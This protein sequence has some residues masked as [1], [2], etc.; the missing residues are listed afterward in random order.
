MTKTER[1][2]KITNNKSNKIKVE[3]RSNKREYLLYYKESLVAQVS[4]T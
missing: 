1:A 3:I 2:N 4:P